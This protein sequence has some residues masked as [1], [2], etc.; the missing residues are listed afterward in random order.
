MVS[1]A[2]KT[3]QR[4]SRRAQH[5]LRLVSGS[6]RQ[7]L[8][9]VVRR[10]SQVLGRE[11]ELARRLS[12]DNQ[13][14]QAR[15]SVSEKL[16]QRSRDL[17]HSLRRASAY[18]WRQLALVPRQVLPQTHKLLRKAL[19]RSRQFLHSL[20]VREKLSLLVQASWLALRLLLAA[21]INGLT[22]A[23][24]Q[25]V[26]RLKERHLKPGLIKLQRAIRGAI[27]RLQQ[28]LGRI[29]QALR[30]IGRKQHRS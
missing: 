21:I 24:R 27:N 23:W 3:P 20:Q 25:L 1:G 22:K 2:T 12:Q 18:T 30:R 8:Q 26:G 19:H 15:A 5:L 13:P 16:R 28:L 4:L 10:A 29:K 9:E 7:R 14:S 11:Y 6:E 17:L